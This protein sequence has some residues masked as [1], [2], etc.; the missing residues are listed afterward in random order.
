MIITGFISPGGPFIDNVDQ[1]VFPDA[2]KAL[3][4]NGSL[5]HVVTLLGIL[6]SLAVA[7]GLFSFFP[8]AGREGGFV[9]SL[10]RF[11][12]VLNLFHYAIFILEGACGTSS[13]WSRTTESG[14]AT[15]NKT[16]S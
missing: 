8:L 13:S 4:D 16:P 1:T 11:G 2:I 15:M 5:T 6:A 3:A 12:L 14:P 7:Y 9:H 10:L